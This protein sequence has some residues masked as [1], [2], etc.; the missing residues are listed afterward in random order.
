LPDFLVDAF[1]KSQ[2]HDGVHP[3]LLQRHEIESYVIEPALFVAAAS[4]V[5]KKLSEEDAEAA[6][7]DAASEL[8]AEARRMSRES[9]KAVNRHLDNEDRKKEAD[10]EIEVD[11][12]FDKLDLTSLNVIQ[13]VFPG[14][15]LM[16]KTLSK[17][18]SDGLEITRGH[19]IASLKPEL[20][21]ADVRDF[22]TNEAARADAEKKA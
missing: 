22:I 18:N 12:W 14:K 20:V 4:L 1:L 2:A 15:E 11:K 16:N 10:L 6:I 5:G 3:H 17:L 19:V 9:A 21:A 13:K 7:M 8:K